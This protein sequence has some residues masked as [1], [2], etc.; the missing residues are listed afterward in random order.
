MFPWILACRHEPEPWQPTI[1]TSPT[2]DTAAPSE[3]EP[4]PTGWDTCARLRGASLLSDADRERWS[5]VSATASGE[6]DLVGWFDGLLALETATLVPVGEAAT[7]LARYGPDGALRWVRQ[8]DGTSQ[9]SIE[10]LSAA[11]D[12]GVY[13][14]GTADALSSFAPG[15]PLGGQGEADVFVARFGPWGQLRW[16]RSFGSPEEDLPYTVLALPDGGVLVGGS[17]AG[18]TVLGA[19]EYAQTT[20]HLPEGALSAAFLARYTSYGALI[21]AI[22]VGGSEGAAITDLA[23]EP[24]Q[25]LLLVQGVLS[26]E[27][28]VTFGAG[29][30]QERTIEPGKADTWLARFDGAGVFSW[31]SDVGD[32]AHPRGLALWP[33]GSS[34]M[35]GEADGTVVFGRG[36]PGEQVLPET[37]KSTAWLAGHEEGQVRWVRGLTSPDF[38]EIVDIATLPWG[39]GVLLGS[40]RGSARLGAGG[41]DEL[42]LVS[43]SG[44]DGMLLTF[45]AEGQLGCAL[46]LQA[47]PGGATSYL[48]PEALEVRSDGGIE[49]VGSLSGSVWLGLEGEVRLYSVSEDG[50]RVIVDLL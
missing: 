36:E 42:H 34:V 8:L 22:S 37:D 40:F 41:P 12:G 45:D 19:G 18:T 32:D 21:W 6:I 20:L 30:P 35:A 25:D 27:G 47:Q 1:S 50:L 29:T 9:A 31:L 23:Y 44:R 17:Y 11:P 26:G 7:L 14:V 38:V 33:D 39:G 3:P 28:L 49:I 5:A 16:A 15:E 48:T 43:E 2:A 46:Q 4:S 10:D 13:A 24:A